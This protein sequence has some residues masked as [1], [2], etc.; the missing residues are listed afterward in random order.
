MKASHQPLRQSP[1]VFLS[2]LAA[3]NWFGF[4]AWNALL[5]NFAKEE[6]GFDGFAIGILQSVREVPGLLAVTALAFLL[7]IREQTLAYA[8]LLML[9]AG[10]ALTGFFPNALGLWL[11]TFVMSVGF[12]YYETMAQSLS[13]QL[14]SKTEAPKVLGRLS[15]V[16]AAGQF[17]AFGGI[18]LVWWAFQPSYTVVFAV[19]GGMCFVAALAA[20]LWFPNFTGPVPQ[21]KNMVLRQRYWLYYAMTFMS[22]S[23]RQIFMAFGAFLLV[24]KFG[25]GVTEISVLMLATYSI[26]TIVG[27]KLGHLIN[28]IGERRTIIVENISLIVVF[29]GYALSQSSVVVGLCFVID[30]VFFTFTIAQRTYFQKIADPADIAP[31]AGVAFTINHIAAVFIPVVFGLI[32]LRDPSLVF[33]IGAALASVS[34][35]LAFL[36]PR[37][38]EPG[39]ETVLTGARRPAAAE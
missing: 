35:G 14:F 33:T 4:A 16:A 23:R 32:W 30:G 5:N 12:H 36:V 31:T 29:A 27:P 11:T 2:C 26:N 25:F 17:V 22:G 39:A 15:A 9:G 24:E 28:A 20:I 34:L 7:I 10:V 18:A 8:S 6:A 21:R 19:T 1:L 38:P 3:I 37:H 13:L